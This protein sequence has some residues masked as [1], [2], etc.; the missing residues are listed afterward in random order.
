[1]RILLSGNLRRYTSFEHDIEVEA[2]SVS[3]AIGRLVERFPELK[4]VL[5]DAEGKLRSVHRVHLN[6]EVL[7]PEHLDDPTKAS[8]EL[9]I[10]T[11]IAGG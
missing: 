1:M 2:S 8:D 7:T 11:A 4:H 5:Y 9:G 10:L 3:S 6:S